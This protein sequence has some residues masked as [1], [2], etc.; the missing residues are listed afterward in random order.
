[1][2]QGIWSWLILK[3]DHSSRLDIILHCLTTFFQIQLP[4]RGQWDGEMMNTSEQFRVRNTRIWILFQGISRHFPR[5]TEKNQDKI[6]GNSNDIR[7]KY[8]LNT[9]LDHYRLTN[10]F[11][12]VEIQKNLTEDTWVYG[13]NSYPVLRITKPES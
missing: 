1:M 8:I 7:T 11:V 10:L 12:P 13:R 9:I 2:G 6:I 5:V 3:Y 4:K